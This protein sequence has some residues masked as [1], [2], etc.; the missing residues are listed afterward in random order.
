MDPSLREYYDLR[1][2]VQ[3]LEARG[4][5]FQ[6]LFSSIMSKAHPGDF[7]PCRPWG[8]DGD[9][10]NDGYL[11]SERTLFQVYA[12]N[13]MVQAR[14]LRKIEEDFLG[15]LPY[16]REHFAVWVF[17]HNARALAPRVIEKLL[18]L[19]RAHPP[20]QIR[21]WGSDEILSRFRL[22][23]VDS[24]RFLYGVHSAAPDR[25][26]D[27]LVR[28]LRRLIDDLARAPLAPLAPLEPGTA[29]TDAAVRIEL[30]E[31]VDAPGNAESPPH[32]DLEEA[33]R[34]HS[35]LALVGPGGSGKTTALRRA[36]F[37]QACH[38][39]ADPALVAGEAPASAVPVL[40]RFSRYDGDLLATLAAVLMTDLATT[41]SLLRRE[42]VVL[43]L[44]DFDQLPQKRHLL[45]D[46][47]KLVRVAPATRYVLSTRPVPALATIAGSTMRI[48]DVAPLSDVD[49]E[50]LFALYLGPDD[51]AA[52]LQE[53]KDRG[54]AEAFRLPIMAWLAA[55]E[56]RAS[57]A[58]PL[59]TAKGALFQ[60]ILD[61]LLREWSPRRRE[62][63]VDR[64]V[65]LKVE[66]LAGLA[67]EMVSRDA[68]ALATSDALG[69]CQAVTA[70][71]ASG[72]TPD[73]ALLLEDLT[74]EPL[75]SAS[76]VAV[77]FRHLSWR[78][79]FAGRW[80]ALH[81]GPWTIAR[82]ALQARWQQPVVHLASM[83]DEARTR[84]LL[85][86][87]IRP[88]PLAIRGCSLH[89]MRWC[90][91]WLLLVL[92][93]LIETRQPV[94]DL[95]DGF[96]AIIG[97][98][99]RAGALYLS[100][101]TYQPFSDPFREYSL[102]LF[103]LIGQ[104]GTPVTFTYL[105]EVAHRRWQIAGVGHFPH[106]EAAAILLSTFEDQP[107]DGIAEGLAADRLLDLPADLAFSTIQGF[108]NRAVAASKAR[109][110]NSLSSGIRR[111]R[112]P[113]RELGRWIPLMVE[114]A[115]ADA[116]ADVRGAALGFLR[117]D[118]VWLFGEA[119]VLLLQA[120][121]S[122]DADRRLH[123]I[124]PLVYSRTAESLEALV[125][126][127]NDPFP[128][129]R[130]VALD[131]LRIRNQQSFPDHAVFVLKT[132]APD[133]MEQNVAQAI[134]DLA[135]SRPETDRIT[136]EKASWLAI[137]SLPQMHESVRWLSVDA[138][139]DL[140]M[141]TT[142]LL[143]PIF[144]HDESPRVR[145]EALISIVQSLGKDDDATLPFLV[146]G[147]DD[148]DDGVRRTAGRLCRHLTGNAARTVVP[149]LLELSGRNSE[150]QF[151]AD[152]LLATMNNT[153]ATGAK[154]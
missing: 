113:P 109:L 65:D 84:A 96:L 111:R 58:A 61:R 46:L 139:G 154:P 86:M 31:R 108:L 144:E 37:E 131:A 125:R 147:L 44:D 102:D 2:R 34:H 87:L 40:L 57:G 39:A 26:A 82:L 77:E 32:I 88:T 152:Q 42:R 122:D 29:T 69:V 138:M 136:L 100:R 53:L 114:L 19:E 66:C 128:W 132:L 25:P 1:F 145:A 92:H 151:Y 14:M 21:S 18:A 85:S 48:F 79:H 38:L 35:R 135:A 116:D 137:G 119:E 115:L 11:R 91:D 153:D 90:A 142:P 63:L 7:I 118:G 67:H 24:L 130:L 51:A 134:T 103:S 89:P 59:S 5:E 121:G 23:P 54:L 143:A 20:I 50:N 140:A 107:G 12:P 133:G 16:W 112:V 17:V 49:L 80:L 10:K 55:V 6:D 106:A 149:K 56:F 98:P 71:H 30:M 95:R 13:E 28:Y 27:V 126:T 78:D 120:L 8:A 3:F 72:A 76:A 75:L 150:M 36:V 148:P 45:E 41:D 110:I 129:P 83:L 15:A 73:S 117:D 141:D 81:A 146:R 33:M 124:W 43:F 123:A 52:L 70:L 97:P 99:A 93:C 64:T 68:A 101:A 47:E 94:D 105:R 4:E 74:A 127:L 22:L 104:L 60:R 9:R 62:D